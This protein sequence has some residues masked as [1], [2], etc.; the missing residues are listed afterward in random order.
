MKLKLGV[1]KPVI[2]ITVTE[3]VHGNGIDNLP[4]L[5]ELRKGNEENMNDTCDTGIQRITRD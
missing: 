4:V 1:L 2:V 5:A 3:K